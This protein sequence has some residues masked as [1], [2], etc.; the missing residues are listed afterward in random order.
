MCL[1][2]VRSRV[3]EMGSLVVANDMNEFQVTSGEQ[4]SKYTVDID[5]TFDVAVV[6]LVLFPECPAN[7]RNDRT[8]P[9]DDVI[10]IPRLKNDP[11]LS[12]L[13]RI[14]LV[15]GLVQTIFLVP[16]A[17]TRKL[18]SIVADAPD[19]RVAH[20]EPPIEIATEKFESA[21]FCQKQPQKRVQFVGGK[22]PLLQ[23]FFGLIEVA[24]D[25]V[26]GAPKHIFLF[27]F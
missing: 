12:A 10:Q 23:F 11:F 22:I 9:L 27:G 5:H 24:P 26:L 3:F 19:F 7:R 14:N 2:K 25:S 16:P 15:S 21:Q 6:F 18:T 13:V 17:L 1:N 20:A 8:R 4:I